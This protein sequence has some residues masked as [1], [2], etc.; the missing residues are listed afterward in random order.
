[1]QIW[2]AKFE[3]QSVSRAVVV[4]KIRFVP[5][6]KIALCTAVVSMFAVLSP[7]FN[8]EQRRRRPQWA[9]KFK[10]VQAQNKSTSRIFF[11]QIPFFC[12]F[13]IG[14]ISFFELGKSLKLSKMQF[15]KKYFLIYLISQV[16]LPGLF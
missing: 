2:R 3:T 7:L 15:H 14:Q 11:Y 9:R 10:K 16:F 1:M 6:E 12:N 4:P 5:L 8:V 13:K